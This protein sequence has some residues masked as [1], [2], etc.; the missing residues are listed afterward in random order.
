MEIGIPRSVQW[1]VVKRHIAEAPDCTYPCFWI[2][3]KQWF[4][5]YLHYLT[6]NPFTN[7]RGSAKWAGT[8]WS[9]LCLLALVS[10]I[11][12]PLRVSLSRTHSS[13][14]HTLGGYA[15]LGLPTALAHFS[16]HQLSL[17]SSSPCGLSWSF[18]PPAPSLSACTHSSPSQT[19]SKPPGES[20]L[21]KDDLTQDQEKWLFCLT[22]I[23]TKCQRREM[24]MFQMKEQQKCRKNP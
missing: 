11:L 2:F 19:L 22:Q 3:E 5:R 8:W 18:T 17:R 15:A 12:R 10:A 6:R 20:S 23:K 21:H 4:K 7:T 24:N 16:P 9:Y 1:S 14:I 13:S